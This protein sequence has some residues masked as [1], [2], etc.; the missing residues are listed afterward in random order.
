[1][2]LFQRL[3]EKLGNIHIY[4]YIQNPNS[5]IPETQRSTDVKIVSNTAAANNYRT[6]LED[7]HFPPKMLGYT[8][9]R[10]SISRR[11]EGGT[12]AP[13]TTGVQPPL[14]PY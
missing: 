8:D 14:Y 13:D 9:Y 3:K 12:C 11:F 4:I 7:V 6:L 10:P 5:N 2:N 1:M